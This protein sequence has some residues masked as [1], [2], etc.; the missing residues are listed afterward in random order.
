ME[1]NSEKWIAK[2]L[3]QFRVGIEK[4]N[5]AMMDI[6][7]Q[8]DHIRWIENNINLSFDVTSFASDNIKLDAWQKP[9]IEAQFNERVRRVVIVAVEQIGK[10]TCWRMPLI[11][12]MLFDP[13]P[14]WVIFESDDKAQDVNKRSF[15]PL[16]DSI[17]ALS[18][19]MNRH[20]ARLNG[21]DFANGA[22]LD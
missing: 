14:N 18:E 2:R 11:Y 5:N 1:E 19:L 3:E 17:P 15:N 4:F 16:L 10:S 9:I 12:K 22:I 21:Y 13:S 7:L 6:E 8:P 20:T